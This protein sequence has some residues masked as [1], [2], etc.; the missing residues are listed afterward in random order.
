MEKKIG[1]RFLGGW[2]L[3]LVFFGPHGGSCLG[4]WRVH[5]GI[6]VEYCKRRA[7]V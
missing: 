7:G 5:F 1:T 4:H 6:I 2:C 3:R